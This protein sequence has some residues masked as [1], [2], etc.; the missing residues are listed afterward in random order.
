MPERVELWTK[1]GQRGLLIASY[2][3]LEKNSD[4][5]ITPGVEAVHVPEHLAL[6][7]SPQAKQLCQLHVQLSLGQSCHRQKKCC[8]YACRVA[9]VVLN[10]L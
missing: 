4:R 7:G 3:R 10:S 1:T 5:A 2:K 6:P 8:V 9:L